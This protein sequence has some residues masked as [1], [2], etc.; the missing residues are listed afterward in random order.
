[1]IK[2]IGRGSYSYVV[3]ARKKD[4]GQLYAIK[5]MKKENLFDRISKKIFA[6]ESDINKK[7]RGTPFVAETHYAFQTK[8]EMFLVME[9]CPGGTLFDYLRKISRETLNY[10]IVRFYIA[11]IIIA[12]EFIHAKNVMY[13]DL[14]PENIIIDIDGHIKLTDFGLSKQCE[15]RNEVSETF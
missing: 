3:V 6:S 8:E 9:L 13:R 2:I 10:D 4:S 14:K 7:F 12:L 11:E 15:T 5:I 1:L